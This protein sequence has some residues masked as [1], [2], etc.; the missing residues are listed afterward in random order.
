MNIKPLSVDIPYGMACRH[1]L[2]V[3]KHPCK[4]ALV[5]LFGAV[6]NIPKNRSK[7]LVSVPTLK[8]VRFP[9]LTV[10]PT[11]PPSCM[12]SRFSIESVNPD[13]SP[14][15]PVRIKLPLAQNRHFVKNALGL[16][17][18]VRTKTNPQTQL[19]KSVSYT[20]L[21]LPTILLV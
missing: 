12:F 2:I 3:F 15:D 5:L 21:T 4:T 8:S 6:I 1:S 13:K 9:T 17:L 10:F 19:G 11:S 20:H 14:S 7:K 16:C 18:I